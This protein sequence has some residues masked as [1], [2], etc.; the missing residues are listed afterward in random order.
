MQRILSLPRGDLMYCVFVARDNYL[1]LCISLIIDPWHMMHRGCVHRYITW[2]WPWGRGWERERG[3][4]RE[5]KRKRMR[6]NVKESAHLWLTLQSR[7]NIPLITMWMK[8]S[9]FHLL[10]F[11]IIK[12]S[13]LIQ[14][15]LFS[16]IP[17]SRYWFISY[18]FISS[19]A[20]S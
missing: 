7:A 8:A 6:R 16:P 11:L 15:S 5:R 1:P 18:R 12:L 17:K 20:A 10:M 3:S 4:E 2:S 14:S 13:D 19:I 9:A